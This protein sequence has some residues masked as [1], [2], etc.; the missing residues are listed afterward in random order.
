MTGD[1]VEIG[2]VGELPP[3]GMKAFELEGVRLLL[4]FSQGEYFVVD[5][6]CTHEDYSLALGCVR[7]C[8]IKCSLHGS[9]FDLRSGIPQEEPAEEPIRSYPV[10]LDGDRILMSF[11]A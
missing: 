10:Q 7:D 9:W 6:M 3:D 4:V 8:R 2:R 1:F 11:Q 5:E